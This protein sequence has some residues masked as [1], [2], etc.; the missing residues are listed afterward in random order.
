M[1]FFV[2][3]AWHQAD[4][5]NRSARQVCSLGTLPVSFLEETVPTGRYSFHFFLKLQCSVTTFA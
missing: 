3:K 5:S 4:T 1:R 2:T